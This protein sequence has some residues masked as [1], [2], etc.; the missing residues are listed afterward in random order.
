MPR[1]G[2]LVLGKERRL[3]SRYSMR[4]RALRFL[5]TETCGTL[6]GVS[7]GRLRI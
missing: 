7:Y 4:E 5:Q 6:H 3:L 1:N 2:W